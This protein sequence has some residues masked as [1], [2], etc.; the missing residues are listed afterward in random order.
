MRP[1]ERVGRPPRRRHE[2]STTAHLI[3]DLEL[4][5]RHLGIERWLVWGVSWG[6]V[7]GLRYAQRAPTR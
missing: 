3:A 4:L 1:F 5:R 6:S 7:L 2:R